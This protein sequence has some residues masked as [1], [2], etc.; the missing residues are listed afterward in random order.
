M[1][2]CF[3]GTGNSQLVAQKLAEALGAE[4]SQDILAVVFPVHAWGIPVRMEEWLRPYFEGR[5]WKY[6]CL[7]MTC[8]SEAGYCERTFPYPFHSA[9]SVVMPNTYVALPFFNT[10]GERLERRKVEA[11][12]QRV[13]QIADAIR[14]RSRTIDV[15]RGIWPWLMTYK[16]RPFFSRH[17]A[18]ARHIRLREDQCNGCGKCTRVCPMA[19]ITIQ[20]GKPRHGTDCCLCLGCYHNCPQ[21]A[22]WVGPYG[23]NK[24]QKVLARK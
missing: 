16:I 24:G 15:K 12:G 23:K 1:I 11:V 3:S 19:N 21:K 13:Q 2:A 22:V 9:Y 10:D 8:G 17:L 7:V 5:T 18:Q 4:D 6:V 14:S 20:Q